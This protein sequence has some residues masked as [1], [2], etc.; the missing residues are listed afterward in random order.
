MGGVQGVRLD[1]SDTCDLPASAR[2]RTRLLVCQSKE[3]HW[4]HTDTVRRP[5]GSGHTTS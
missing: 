3:L 1:Y 4:T 2:Y 5:L